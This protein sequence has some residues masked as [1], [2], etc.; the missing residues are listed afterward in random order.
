MHLTTRAAESLLPGVQVSEVARKHGVTRWQV[1]DWRRRLDSEVLR[2][3]C[4]LP[5]SA[6]H[7]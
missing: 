4:V 1:Y 2:V 6:P 3:A 7:G 5:G